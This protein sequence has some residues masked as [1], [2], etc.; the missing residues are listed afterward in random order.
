MDDPTGGMWIYFI[1]FLIPLVRIIPR[2]LRRMKN[3]NSTKPQS[4]F[5][6]Q[7]FTHDTND[8]MQGPSNDASMQEHPNEIPTRQTNDMLVLGE[9]NKGTKQFDKIQKNT[10]LD[11]NELESI[12]DDLERQGLMR[13]EHKKGPFGSKIELHSTEKGFDKY[14]S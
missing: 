10:N 12:L 6:S 7:Q 11:S 5:F 9:L 4:S 13:V 2:M 14:Y 1:F 3:K 8:T